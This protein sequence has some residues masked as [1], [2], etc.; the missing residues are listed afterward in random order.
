MATTLKHIDSIPYFGKDNLLEIAPNINF[1]EMIFELLSTKKPN[2]AELKIFETI[3]NLSIDHGEETPSAIKTIEAAKE[4]KTI[5]ESVSAGIL[6]IND[7]HGGAIEPAMEL[8]YKIKKE[9]LD[10]KKV[11]YDY[12]DNDRRMPGFGHR[13]YD[14]DPR[15]QLLFKLARQQKISEEFIEIAEILEKTLKSAKGKPIPVNI[16]GAIASILCTFGWNSNLGKA[17][18]IIARTPGLCGQFLNNSK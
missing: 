15:A 11:I 6:Q 16:D 1:S 4:G 14:I 5:S 13:I 18:F 7:T 2:E 17:V 12:L 8:F 9:K 10:I 3:L